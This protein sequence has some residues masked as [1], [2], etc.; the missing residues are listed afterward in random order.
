MLCTPHAQRSC[1]AYDVVDRDKD[2]LHEKAD[3]AH[4][5]EANRSRLCNLR[6]LCDTRATGGV[7]SG[8]R[9]EK[10]PASISPLTAAEQAKP[11]WSLLLHPC[12]A[13]AGRVGRCAAAAAADDG[14]LSLAARWLFAASLPACW[15]LLWIASASAGV[16]APLLCMRAPWRS[17]F[18]QRFTRRQLSRMNS[19]VGFFTYSIASLFSMAAI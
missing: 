15:L 17:G 19:S 3:E 18:V 10:E 5:R 4:D 6:E 1:A 12:I 9:K 7:S 14:Q 16:L 8:S 2:Q 13:N 11:S